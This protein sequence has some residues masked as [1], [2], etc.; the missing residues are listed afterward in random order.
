MIIVNLVKFSLH[1]GIAPDRFCTF[2]NFN[3]HHRLIATSTELQLAAARA[4]LGIKYTFEEYLADDLRS[5]TLVPILSDWWQSFSGPYL[6]YP[7]RTYMPAPLRA[8]ID[9]IKSERKP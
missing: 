1:L 2:F 6:Y 3:D 8:F 7:S 4:G 9:F 5:G